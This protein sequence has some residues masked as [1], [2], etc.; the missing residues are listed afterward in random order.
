MTTRIMESAPQQDTPPASSL[1]DS[2]PIERDVQPAA[3]GATTRV[4]ERSPSEFYFD[5]QLKL[6]RSS[7]IMTWG[8]SLFAV[9]TFIMGFS[10]LF[11]DDFIYAGVLFVC[12]GVAFMGLIV[13]V[14]AGYK[15]YAK[16]YFSVPIA[17]L[18]FFLVLHGGVAQT[19]LYWCLAFTPGML[20][21]VGPRLGSGLFVV[22]LVAVGVIFYGD[23][24]PWPERAYTSAHEIR[25]LLAFTG[26]ALFSLGH[27]HLLIKS[28]L[29][30]PDW[31]SRI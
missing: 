13:A 18:F 14:V 27:D 23:L 24:Y 10:G 19:G 16:W 30:D 12:S 2:P 15:S 8:M 31:K 7:S 6:W 1:A 29:G 25:F 20:Y 3:A 4:T 9:F 22:T 28:G 5:T 21:M 26:A 11:R 17:I